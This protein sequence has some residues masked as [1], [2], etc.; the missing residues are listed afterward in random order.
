MKQW[1]SRLPIR[2]KLILLAAIATCVGLLVSGAVLVY[3]ANYSSDQAL[4]HRLQT[5]ARIMALNSSAALAFEDVEAAKST[6]LA[7]AGDTAI[8]GADIERSDGT[9]FVEHAF[10]EES[11]QSIR[12]RDD[13]VHISADIILDERIGAVHI[14]ASQ[15]EIRALLMR[16]LGILALAAI[17]SLAL[18]LLAA[19]RLQRIISD[20][21][22]VLADTAETVSRTRDYTVRVTTASQDEVGKLVGAFNEMLAQTDAQAAELRA[23]QTELEQK[24][25]RRTTELAGALRDAQAAVQAKADFLANMSHEIRTPMNGVIG[26]LDLLDPEGLDQQRRSM[27]DT[28]RNS[29]EALLGIINDVLDFSKIDAGK[30]T[31]EDIDLEL[32]S[33][34]EEVSTLFARQAHN[35]GVEV[36]CLVDASVPSLVRGDPVR[37]RQIFSNLLGNAIKFTEHGEVSLSVRSE[38][39]SDASVDIII[40]IRDTGI[41]MTEAAVSRLFQSFTQADSSTTR[42]YG[43]TG[44]GLAI[45]K[46][47][48]DAMHGTIAVESEPGN[49]T[50]FTVTLPMQVGVAKPGIRRA[51]LSGFKV[52]VIDDNATNRAVVEQYLQ[53]LR[54]RCR[55]AQSAA[56]GLEMTRHARASGEPFDMIVLDYQMPEVDG[57]G[58]MRALRADPKIADTKCLVLSSVGDRQADVENLDIA[59]WLSK[60]LRQGQLYSAIAMVAGVSAG[61]KATVAPSNVARPILMK[62]V[63]G[64]AH[65]LLVEDNVVNQQV[66]LRMLA[67]FGLKAQ[68]A[69]NGVEAVERA[70]NERFDAIFMDCQMPLMDGYQAT[71][72][73]REWER[74]E[75]QPRAPIIAMTANAMQGDRERCLEAGMDDYLSKPLKRDTL[76]VTLTKWLAEEAAAAAHS[77]VGV[78]A[79]VDD[80]EVLDEEAFAQLCELFD[81]DPT[82]IIDSYLTDSVLQ[83]GIMAN[84]LNESDRTALGRSAHSLKGSSRSLGAHG[85]ASIAEEIEKLAF[86]GGELE[87]ARALVARLHLARAAAEPQLRAMCSA[88]DSRQTGSGN[89][90]N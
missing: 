81:G 24:V 36:T 15:S 54:I 48:V 69:L 82:E 23:Y 49:G 74:S 68:V 8:L 72:A 55:G 33:L 39:K 46:R 88:Q 87:S 13:L 21:I 12:R 10:G 70:K 78:G 71:H 65:V 3:Y 52:L 50:I 66:A 4:Q 64:N 75:N 51:D 32:L 9:R 41:G 16:A 62:G 44:L 67:A 19:S 5:Q 35:K 7:L 53:T 76:S 59:A 80:R 1:L 14:W 47:L 34:A 43:G 79:G 56:E 85:I 31:L 29:A 77:V 61:W 45:T 38:R 17:A 83:L 6:L 42:K 40:T 28:A 89:R 73:I 58:F 30:L 60:P 20:P 63:R 18:A 90:R 84:A 37:V 26:M 57:L 25:E 22:L 86:S 11:L 2:G 27:L